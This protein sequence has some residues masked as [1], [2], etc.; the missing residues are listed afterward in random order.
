M[1]VIGRVDVSRVK[2][3]SRNKVD[4]SCTGS[5]DEEACGQ[6]HHLHHLT[7]AG[8]AGTHPHGERLT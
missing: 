5:G 3:L 2:S 7:R 1:V 4:D 6:S 8:P